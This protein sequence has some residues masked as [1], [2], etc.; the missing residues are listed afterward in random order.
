MALYLPEVT[1]LVL[2]RAMRFSLHVVESAA[3]PKLMRGLQVQREG[4]SQ[5]DS[6]TRL[7]TAYV[8]CYLGSE[9]HVGFKTTA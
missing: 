1:A 7:S 3:G 2:W 5:L 6:A 4:S 8:D 9:I